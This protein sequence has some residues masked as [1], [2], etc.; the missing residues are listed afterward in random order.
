MWISTQ[1][2]K[3]QERIHA[4]VE[5]SGPEV[6]NFGFP[7]DRLD[8]TDGETGNRFAVRREIVWCVG[9]MVQKG[10]VDEGIQRWTAR[11]G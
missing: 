4:S 7:G 8:G 11:A 1:H 5:S 3:T 9:E 6:V 2:G 10:A